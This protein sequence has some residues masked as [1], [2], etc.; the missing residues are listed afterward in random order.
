MRLNTE[1]TDV[2]QDNSG[3]KEVGR[4]NNTGHVLIIVLPG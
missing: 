4:Q 1:S 2:L 3:V